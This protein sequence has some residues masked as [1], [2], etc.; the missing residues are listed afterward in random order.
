M[1]FFHFLLLQ[2]PPY[3]FLV[4]SCAK[5]G[6][7]AH[8]DSLT[9][10][11]MIGLGSN[12]PCIGALLLDASASEQVK[13]QRA[14]GMGYMADKRKYKSV[15]RTAPTLVIKDVWVTCWVRWLGAALLQAKLKRLEHIFLIKPQTFHKWIGNKGALTRFIIAATKFLNGIFA[16]FQLM[17]GGKY[18]WMPKGILLIRQP[19][20]CANMCGIWSMVCRNSNFPGKYL[21][22]CLWNKV[23]LMPFRLAGLTFRGE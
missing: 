13:Q 5:M 12:H 22:E 17:V 18:C 9:A 6:R 10:P 20:C 3:H 16:A 2:L 4:L 23:Y 19:L 8:V 14:P 1:E 11:V 15:S 21:K 7:C